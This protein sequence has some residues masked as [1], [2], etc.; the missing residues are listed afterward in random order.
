MMKGITLMTNIE[1]INSLIQEVEKT[2]DKT[3]AL[4]LIH[5]IKINLALI[6]ENNISNQ[7]DPLYFHIVR[8]EEGLVNAIVEEGVAGLIQAT[9]KLSTV[10]DEISLEVDNLNKTSGKIENIAFAV[11]IT[12]QLLEILSKFIP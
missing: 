6:R 12:V 10:V 8:L 5:A 2:P 9:M 1:N 4:A 7:L 3:R 11:K